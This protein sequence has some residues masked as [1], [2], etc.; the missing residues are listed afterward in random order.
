MAK[1]YT[2]NTSDDA[3]DGHEVVRRRHD[4]GRIRYGRVSRVLPSGVIAAH[5]QRSGDVKTG[6]VGA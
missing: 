3:R 4:S 6:M 2:V 5:Y 1:N